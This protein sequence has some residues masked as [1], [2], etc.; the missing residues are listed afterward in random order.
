MSVNHVTFE[1]FKYELLLTI[2]A[3]CCSI[4]ICMELTKDVSSFS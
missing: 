2:E 1:L 3:T 4:R